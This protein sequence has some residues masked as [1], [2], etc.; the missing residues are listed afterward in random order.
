M[1]SR[2]EE[3]SRLNAGGLAAADADI[4]RAI[5][6]AVRKRQE[7]ILP[8]IVPMFPINDHAPQASVHAA[9]RLAI[10]D[11]LLS[12]ILQNEPVPNA[13]RERLLGRTA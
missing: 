9:E 6:A 8:D 5:L 4:M 13:V 3:L 1:S 7:A 10:H 12:R 2:V 11:V